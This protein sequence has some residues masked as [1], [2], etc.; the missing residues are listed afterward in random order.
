MPKYAFKTPKMHLRTLKY[1]HQTSR[2]Y[3]NCKLVKSG[4]F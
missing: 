4:T 3:K 1:V 2:L